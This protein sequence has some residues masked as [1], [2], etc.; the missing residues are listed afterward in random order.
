MKIG[1]RLSDRI[2]GDG[3]LYQLVPEREE[4]GRGREGGIE[5]GRESWKRE[6]RERKG[7][8]GKEGGKEGD[9]G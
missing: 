5:G 4:G 7:V 1:Q 8:V 6:W 2:A 3:V 9:G